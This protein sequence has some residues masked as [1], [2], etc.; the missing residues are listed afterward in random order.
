MI[1]KNSLFN[2]CISENGNGG[3]IY[4]EIDFTTQYYFEII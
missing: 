2:K 4:L 1:I 3:L